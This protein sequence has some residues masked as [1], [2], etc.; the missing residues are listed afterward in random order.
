MVSTVV[1][2]SRWFGLWFRLWFGLWFRLWFGLRFRLWFRLRG[3]FSLN[4]DCMAGAAALT[5]DSDSRACHVIACCHVRV[6]D[7]S[8]VAKTS[9]AVTEVPSQFIRPPMALNFSSERYCT[10]H[11]HRSRCDGKTDC[12]S[13]LLCWRLVVRRR[14]ST[15]TSHKQCDYQHGA[16]ESDVAHLATSSL[17]PPECT[18]V[19]TGTM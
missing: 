1:C 13:W 9:C 15:S 14:R 16:D 7:A 11:C 8:L 17:L 4:G 5:P 6:R 2:V 3:C 18:F 19:I 10:A 12:R